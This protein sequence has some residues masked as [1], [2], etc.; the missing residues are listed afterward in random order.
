MGIKE[1]RLVRDVDQ[2]F[3]VVDSL[4]E[5]MN[6]LNSLVESELKKIFKTVTHDVGEVRMELIALRATAG[7][8]VV[9]NTGDCTNVSGGQVN[10]GNV[11]AEQNQ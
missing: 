11:T 1:D 10:Q 2:L 8:S 7:K 5:R 3:T 4:E 6:K 9:V